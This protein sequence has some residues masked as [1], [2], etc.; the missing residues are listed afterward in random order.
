MLYQYQDLK[1]ELYNGMRFY[2]TPNG[3]YPSITTVLGSTQSEEKT[4]SLENWRES[5]GHEKAEAFTKKAADHG[6]VVHLLAERYLKNLPV[7]DDID[8]VP[9]LQADRA[10]FNTLKIK[11]SRINEIWG[12]EVPLFSKYWGIAG[13]CDLVGKYNDIP[14]IIDFK[15]S[16]KIKNRQDIADYE[17]QLLFYGDAHNEMFNTDIKEGV[18]LMVAKT[19]FPIEFKVPFTDELRKLLQERLDSFWS[20]K[21]LKPPSKV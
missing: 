6:T 14:V 16:S 19:G 10:A 2:H 15:T 11:L 7:F 12:Q 4:K 21:I 17:L 3:A 18:I 8:S 20:K 9:I 5:L 13:R 1:A